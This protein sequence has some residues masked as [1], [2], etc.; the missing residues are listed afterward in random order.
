MI[1]AAGLTVLGLVLAGGCK[2][3]SSGQMQLT[4]LGATHPKYKPGQTWRYRTRAGEEQSTLTI[5]R[6]E[7]SPKAGTIV[8]VGLAGLRMKNPQAPGGETD[9]ASHLPFTEKA[10]DDSVTTVARQQGPVPEYLDGYN[11]WRKAF[12]A[13]KGGVFT[14]T[15][16]ATVGVMERAM[17]NATP[18]AAR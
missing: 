18:E 11:T 2:D 10:V 16:A 9:S 1:F 5:L 6:V 4:D 3:R 14:T 13:G 12:D 15:V 17:A 7:R 8:H